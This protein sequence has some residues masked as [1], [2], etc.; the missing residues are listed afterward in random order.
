MNTRIIVIGILAVVLLGLY[1]YT[2]VLEVNVAVDCKDKT[3][4]ALQ[5]CREE[6]DKSGF[7]M[8][9]TTVGGLISAVAVGILAA[10]DPDEGAPTAGLEKTAGSLKGL[11]LATI[12]P[13][14]IIFIWIACGVVAI[15]YG[16]KYQS[17]PPLTEMAKAWIGTALAG[18]GAFLGI[19]NPSTSNPPTP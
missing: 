15:I 14:I 12:L 16:F 3:A 8:I 1:I 10:S 13:L 2:M 18:V 19:K 5:K 11:N 4:D 6:V 7:A 9:F 17:S